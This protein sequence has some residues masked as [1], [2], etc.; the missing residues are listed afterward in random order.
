VEKMGQWVSE[1]RNNE[2]I[3]ALWRLL[4]LFCAV[5]LGLEGWRGRRY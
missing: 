4:W 2:S 5:R 3:P 1:G